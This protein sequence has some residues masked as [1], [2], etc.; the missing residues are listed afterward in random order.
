MTKPENT[1]IFSLT[2]VNHWFTK[3]TMELMIGRKIHQVRL[4]NRL[5]LERIA[6]RTGFTKSYISMVERGKKSPPI[7]T[8]SKIAHA[9]G[10]DIGAFFEK[11]KPEDQIT[12]VRKGQGKIAV[13]DGSIFGYRYE[14]IAP[15]KGRKKMEPFILTLPPKSREEGRFDHEGE[16]L[17]YLLEGKVKF[18]YA[19]KEYFLG[20]GDCL[21]FDSSIPHRAEGADG[22]TAK[23]LVVIYT[24]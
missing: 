13:R 7:A 4:Q 12:L 6:E 18:Y 17:F 9:L 11:R 22:R 8:L 2:K 21:Y 24:P 5:T 1:R 23:A 19:D 10:V 20:Q 16:E 14:S 15:A 3:L